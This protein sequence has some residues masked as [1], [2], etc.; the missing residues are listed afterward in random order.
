MEIIKRNPKAFAMAVAMHLVLIFF[1]V[2]GVDWL[3]EPKVVRP[4]VDV[5][6]AKVISEDQI[7]A[8][9]QQLKQEKEKEKA[10]KQAEKTKAEQELTDIKKK[11]EAEKL[12]LADL[13]KKR[14]EEAKKQEEVKKKAEAENK[15]LAELEKKRKKAE[16]DKKAT[17]EAEK[18]RKADLDRKLREDEARLKR[19][20]ELQNSLA[21]EQNARMAEQSSAFAIAV[22]NQVTGNW[23]R[24]PGTGT[25]LKCSLQVRVA[26]NGTVLEVHVTQG[27]GNDAFDRSAEAAVMKSDPLPA[28]PPGLRDLNLIFD[29]DNQ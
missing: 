20:Q 9:A 21:A 26:P 24:P 3:E 1:L 4:H 11:Q 2:F 10:R 28:P 16:D 22:S 7:V 12:R 19:E 18:Q 13:E 15:R 23:L 29:P 5:I 6:Q 27:S 8:E 14:K 17:A 25:G